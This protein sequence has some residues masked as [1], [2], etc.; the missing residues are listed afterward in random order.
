MTWQ[1]HTANTSH[2]HFLTTQFNHS[3][4]TIY[5]FVSILFNIA[6]WP[7]YQVMLIVFIKSMDNNDIYIEIFSMIALWVKVFKNGR[8]FV[9]DSHITSI[10]LKAVLHKF[11]LVHSWIVS[12]N[13]KWIVKL[14]SKVEV[15]LNSKVCGR[16]PYN[17]NFFK[18]VLH[19]FY[20]VHSW[21]PC[22]IYT[23][24]MNTTKDTIFHCPLIEAAI[25][26]AL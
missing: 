13:S 17:V 10:S 14:N 3:A 18:A 6:L 15:I 2:R 9:E 20:L 25:G 19:K 23:C 22:P 8:K 7:A 5:S 26:C 21:I 24:C 11:Y 4:Y 16:Q 1:N 12:L